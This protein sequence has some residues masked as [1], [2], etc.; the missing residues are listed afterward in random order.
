MATIIIAGLSFIAGVAFGI[1][2]IALVS[3]GDGHD[4]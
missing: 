2:L 4:R 3:G 1:V